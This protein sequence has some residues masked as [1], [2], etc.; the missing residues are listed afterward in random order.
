MTHFP[1]PWSSYKHENP[2]DG[3]FVRDAEGALVADFLE[4][5][6][7]DVI[8][9]APEMLTAL[10]EIHSDL[11]HGPVEECTCSYAAIIRKAERQ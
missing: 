8:A 2:R 7:V 3:F 4:V 6:N 5:E 9:A 11:D 1:A 10:K